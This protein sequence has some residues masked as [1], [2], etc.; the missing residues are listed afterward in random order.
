[1]VDVA[2]EAGCSQA[3]VS[4]VL[5]GA[6]GVKISPETSERVLTV[7]RAMGY[8]AS[9]FRALE[10]PQVQVSATAGTIGFLVDQLATS[11]EAAIAIDSAHQEAWRTGRVLVS[12]QTGSDAMMEPKAIQTL[13]SL[14]VSS[15]IYMTIITRELQAHPMLY[16]LDIPV[17]LLNCYTQDHAFASVIPSEIA[18]GQADRKSVV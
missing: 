12:S 11:P 14:G 1:M 8:T 3:T 5:N 17:V 13:L 15:M 4:F 10:Q 18:G 2:R 7:A 16:E 6:A 9:T